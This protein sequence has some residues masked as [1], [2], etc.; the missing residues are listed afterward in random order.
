MNRTGAP[1]HCWLLTLQ[2][3]CYILNHISTASLGGQVPLQVLY[4]VTPDISIILLYTFYQPVF[5][6]THD[7]HFPSDSEERAGYWVGFAEH[8][9]DSLT[10]MVLDAV[11]NIIIY[12]SALRPRTPKDPNKRLVDAGGEEDHQPHENPT[13]PPTPIPNGEKS[14]PSD[15]P[16][17]YI[18][19]RHDDGPTSRKTLPGFNPDDLVGRTFLLPPGDNGERLRAKVTRKVV[20]DIEQADGER[21]QKL[22]FILGI[23]NRKLEEI[24]SYNQLVD[25]LEAAANDDNEISDDLFKFRALICHQGPLKPTD[26]NWNGCKYNVLVD[27]KTGEKTYELLSVLAADD[28]VTCA[29]YAKENDLLHI[30]GWKRFRNLAKRD[31]TLTRAIMQS[32]IRQARRA[33]KYIF[34]YL[35]PRSYKEALEFDKENNNTKWADA[36]RE[37]MDSIK[38]RQVFTKHQRVKWDSRHKRII[39]APP[40]HQMIRVNLIFA[41]KHDGRHKARLVADGSLTSDPVENIYSGVVS[42]RHLRL[43]I[44]LGE[45]N[46]LE[47][48]GA[49]IGNTYLE[50]YTNEKLFIIAGPEFEALEGFILIFN[51]ALHGLKSS[52]KRWAERFY[53]IIK[54]MYSRLPKQIHV[55]G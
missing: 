45:L 8:C 50:A 20:E 39:N 22:S 25:H 28:P 35:I 6:A 13:K 34:G 49:Y 16:T 15:T 21:V 36:T 10:H 4:G 40:N 33:K 54:D 51:K 23:G 17:V 27:W 42:L 44:F 32:R 11:T 12:R 48:W 9:G 24:I 7:Q 53:D 19:S 1:A 3:V 41:V 52:G 18:K 29:L 30:D 14:A 55:S 26:P 47:L 31:K 5:Y 43:V 2:Y 46:N 37:E 38:E